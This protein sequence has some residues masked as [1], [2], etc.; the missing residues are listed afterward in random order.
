MGIGRRHGRYEAL[1]A[2]PDVEAID[3]PSPNSLHA[4]WAMRA[5]TFEQASLDNTAT[6]HALACS[7]R[8]AQW[9]AVA[10]SA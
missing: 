6:L 10:P 2:A 7:A 8:S 9:V 3:L 5:A 4:Q 1:L